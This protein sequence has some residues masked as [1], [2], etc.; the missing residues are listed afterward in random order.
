MRQGVLKI[1]NNK[2]RR[3]DEIT[4]F[5]QTHSGSSVQSIV[6]ASSISQTTTYRIMTEHL[7]IKPCK[8]HFVQLLYEE[9]FQGCVEMY[10]HY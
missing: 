9:D 2:S 6:E 7:L 10:C 3:V 1:D 5:L 4:D 8:E